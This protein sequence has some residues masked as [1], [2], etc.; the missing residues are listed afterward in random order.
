ML[1]LFGLGRYPSA[2]SKT[3]LLLQYN[4]ELSFLPN[5][6][7]HT[8]VSPHLCS[9]RIAS[10]DHHFP[11]VQKRTTAACSNLRLP[12]YLPH[13]CTSALRLSKG[14]NGATAHQCSL[15]GS[16]I[17]SSI[18]RLSFADAQFDFTPRLE[19]EPIGAPVGTSPTTSTGHS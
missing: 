5:I 7:R 12:R 18:S 2:C 15:L 17:P 1:N 9:S 4:L 16:S 6:V 19:H 11:R 3:L 8:H 13:N 10:P 14:M